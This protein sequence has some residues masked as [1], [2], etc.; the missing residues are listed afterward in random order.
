M[1]RMRRMG[2]PLLA[3]AAGLALPATASA[4][5]ETCSLRA[6]QSAF[7][8]EA[9]LLDWARQ[10]E[11]FGPRPTGSAAHD[12]YIDWIEDEVSAI[13]GIRTSELTYEIDRWD[14]GGAT[15]SVGGANVPLAGAVP[16]S[17]A[18]PAGGAAAQLVHI[19]TGTAITAANAAGKIVVRD[20]PWNNV[21]NALFF[22]PLLGWNVY[23]PALTI[24]LLGSDST[25][26]LAQAGIDAAAAKTA[27]AAGVL[28]V[29]QLPRDQIDGTY[30]PYEGLPLG[31]P[32]AFVGVDEGTSLKAAIASGT[33][34]GTFASDVRW[35]PAR[36]RT[37]LAT[38]EGGNERK[39]VVESHT[40]GMNPVWDNGPLSMLAQARYFASL[41]LGC[42][43]KTIQFA[44]VTGHL[45]QHLTGP[46]V[47]EGGAGQ[48][49]AILDREYDE[50]KVAAVVV[51]EH[52]GARRYDAVVRSGGLPGKQLVAHR[53]LNE[54]LLLPVTDSNPL[55][56]LVRSTIYD[57]DVRRTA[58]VK[59]L[60]AADLSTVPHH[61][62]FG[63][64]GTPYV[65]HLLPTVS[66]IAAPKTLFSP[67]FGVE[68]LDVPLMRKATL[69]FTDV[70]LGLGPMSQ[71]DIAG[72]FT[73]MRE[74][75]A[76]GARTC[77]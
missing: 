15:L 32:A 6:D 49:A 14:T 23:D 45:Y 10:L 4:Q 70:I 48:L 16:F 77:V 64:E 20:L 3:L 21:P 27:G 1:G 11:S 60:S 17:A 63:G 28:M 75:R 7:A 46:T 59:G 73:F 33:T 51:L 71:S 37:L 34:T 47:R 36:T 41:P 68:A 57:R 53:T 52:L 30:A 72:D 43:P 31:I 76:R 13:P 35:T 40:D 26:V 69:A 5:A 24:N 65:Q 39:I 61:C 67:Q 66:P 74:Q 25:E 19:P 38:L 22:P 18:T 8:S 42:R 62:S 29:S 9:Q 58:M 50:G 54:L 44:F 2:L 55:R 12:Q 56:S